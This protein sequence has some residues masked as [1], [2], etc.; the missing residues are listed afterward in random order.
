MDAGLAGAELERL[1]EL[2]SFVDFR[3]HPEIGRAAGIPL[4]RRRVNVGL[5]YDAV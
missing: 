3:F 2:L 5:D 4:L 1:R